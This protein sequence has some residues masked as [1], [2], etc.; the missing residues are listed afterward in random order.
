[1]LAERLDSAQ[2]S[3]SGT[4]L[5]L[6]GEAGI[7][8]TALARA[9]SAS[10][11]GVRSLWGACDA[12]ET[13]RP[14]GPLIDVADQVGG[15]LARL[16]AGNPS[17]AAL[18]RALLVEL[19]RRRSLVVLE[20]LHWADG[21]TLD[22]LRLLARRV[23]RVPTVLLATYREDGLGRTHPL[24]VLLGELPISPWIVRLRLQPLSLAAVQKLAEEAGLDPADIYR[25]TR[26][27][28]FFVTEVLAA[29]EG[30]RGVPDTVRD[31]VLARAARLDAAAR[32]LLEVVAVVPPRA[33]MWLLEAT[34]GDELRS[35]DSCLAS[36]MLEDDGN[37]VRFRHEIARVAIE[38]ALPPHLKRTLHRRVLSAL[39]A[40]SDRRP[41]VARLA[42]HAEAAGDGQAVVRYARLAGQRAAA[43][44]AHREAA[45]QFGRALRHAT[46]LRSGE[47]ARLFEARSYECYLTH[48]IDEAIGAR[49]EA[50]TLRREL[51]DMRAVGDGHRWMSMLAWLAGDTETAQTEALRAVEV[52]ERESDGRELAIAYSNLALMRLLVYDLTGTLQ[53]GT[54]A[55]ELARRLGE[56]APLTDALMTIG[57]AELM[58]GLAAGAG[59]LQRALELALEAGLEEQAARACTNLGLTALGARDYELADR[60]LDSCIEYCDAH[61][62]GLWPFYTSGWRARSQLE[63]GRWDAAGELAMSALEHPLV[64]A[65]FRVTPLVVI[66]R[67]RARRGDPDPWSPLDEALHLTRRTGDLELAPVAAARAEA[68]WLEDDPDGVARATDTALTLPRARADGWIL[69]E[70][71]VWRQRAGIEDRAQ[72]DRIAPPF[73]C[74]LRGEYHQAAERWEKLGCPYEAAIARARSTDDGTARAGLKGLQALGARRAAARVARAMRQ[75][76]V[77]DLQLGPRRETTRNPAGLTARE[78]DVLELI[79]DGLR[80][81][82]IAARLSLS[83]KTVDHHVSAI[84]RKLG[85]SSRVKA[86]AEAVRLDIAAHSRK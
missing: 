46:A 29:A 78:L 7:G 61:D 35:L 10:R 72:P 30:G 9:W 74:E 34:A 66:G 45:E 32:R 82:E 16:A 51:G 63:Q 77:R 37:T 40:A 55:I 5:L 44:R 49:R 43:L 65:P 75:R 57:T 27:N 47:R 71:L 76:G 3:G 6:C 20:D 2:H 36:G 41:D 79:V 23:G 28:P 52:L 12:L 42:H 86:A 83:E 48:Q 68:H 53:S 14:L 38:N 11:P 64:A 24:R 21:A 8:K 18:V 13:P 1:M 67:L 69:G 62:L 54:R 85:V 56:L 33:E 73:A 19:E 58:A 25:L 84:L 22:A 50:L 4:L 59:K 80:N 17:P 31:A 15:E 39:G 70:L 81:S 60:Q 26:G